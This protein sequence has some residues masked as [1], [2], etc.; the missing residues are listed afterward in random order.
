M[1]R[2]FFSVLIAVSAA[3]AAEE[4]LASVAARAGAALQSGDYPAAERGYRRVVAMA[5]QMAE[6]YTNLGLSRYLQR[7]YPAAIEA[8]ERGLKLQPGMA[9]AWLFLGI[10]RFNLNR[11][12]Q[13]LTALKKFIEARPGDFQGQYYAGLC[14]LALN[15]YSEAAA[16]LKL[17]LQIDPL[18][19]DGWYHLAQSNLRMAEAHVQERG[20]AGPDP[21]K[22]Q[23]FERGYEDA[24]AK[25]AAIE[26]GSFRIRQLKAGY[27]EATGDDKKAI[28][29]LR[30][31]LSSPALKATGL[32]YT[33]GCLYLKDRDYDHAIAAFEAEL[34]LAAP[35]PR[36][37][38]QLGHAWIGKDEPERALS[39]LT[40]ATQEEPESGVPWVEKGRAQTKVGQLEDAIRSFRKA[41]E[42][43]ED[44]SSVRYLLGTAYR[45][46]GK[47]D[48]A[49]VEFE[50]SQVLS[51][52]GNSQTVK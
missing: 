38:L 28:D 51:Q 50:K 10:S 1:V 13:G 29:E 8:F 22:F 24:V 45:K 4:D 17:A 6:A 19:I 9:N 32:N 44:T 39:F 20:S 21:A 16:Q 2:K 27:Y 15:R 26:P 12:A 14:L 31:M 37:Y 40:R 25:I 11:P 34:Q 43:K 18:N 42:L 33:L 47:L 48:L 41:I 36:T 35:N 23:V 46:A 30:A 49:R 7:E 5:P 52:K 3:C